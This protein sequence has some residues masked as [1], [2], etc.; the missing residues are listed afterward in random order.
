[1]KKLNSYSR[2]ILFFAKQ[3][4]E[5]SLKIEYAEFLRTRPSPDGVV[6][7]GMGGSGL[8]G[9][10]AQHYASILKLP[11]PVHSWE[12]FG[13]PPKHFKHPLYVFISFSGNTVETISA[14]RSVKKRQNITVIATGGALL[15]LAKKE[16][17]PHIAFIA[18]GL[19]PRDSLGYAYFSLQKLLRVYFP[20]IRASKDLTHRIHPK[21]LQ[22]KGKDLAKKLKGTIPILYT[23]YTRGALGY[24]WKIN[25]NETAKQP[26]F[27]NIIPEASHNEIS[28][29]ETASKKLVP[30]F[31]IDSHTTKVVKKK[32]STFEKVLKNR[33][34]KTLTVRLLGKTEEEHL[35]NGVVLGYWVSWYLALENK[36][37]PKETKIIEELKLLSR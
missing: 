25:I 37:N 19:T 22:K 20:S 36:K 21:L 14:F 34:H 1:M 9:I 32:I 27:S 2:H 26:C 5:K 23:D 24:I 7:V 33:N 16:R 30:V 12:N 28:G 18:K 17:I 29:F 13:L 15:A 10:L 11:I 3:L 31:L 8:P 35:W 6:I 4:T